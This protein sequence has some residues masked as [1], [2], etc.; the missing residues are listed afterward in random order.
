MTSHTYLTSFTQL[1][2]GTWRIEPGELI[3]TITVKHRSGP[4]AYVARLQLEQ[5][6]IEIGHGKLRFDL[7][8]AADGLS[9]A[10]HRDPRWNE[11]VL[12]GVAGATVSFD[13]DSIS[14]PAPGVARASG[15]LTHGSARRGLDLTVRVT[16]RTDGPELVVITEADHRELGL[17]WLPSH[18]KAPTQVALRVPRGRLERQ[19]SRPARP[20]DQRY[21]F[22]ANGA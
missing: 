3:S 14:E 10:A 22:M 1:A 8:F 19:E 9:A 17:H 5:G 7:T 16:Q 15:L 2:A 18:L 20:L 12:A 6:R 11:G 4:V 13:S 21:R